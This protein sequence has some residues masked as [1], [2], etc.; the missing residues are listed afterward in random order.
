MKRTVAGR[1]TSTFDFGPAGKSSAMSCATAV[2]AIKIGESTRVSRASLSC[3][4][5]DESDR[6]V[7]F[8]AQ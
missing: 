4:Y 3:Q 2:L 6:R 5:S 1:S 8:A 7:E